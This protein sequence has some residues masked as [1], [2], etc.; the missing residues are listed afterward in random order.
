MNDD[1]NAIAHFLACAADAY[2]AAS[3]F[4][5]DPARCA[6]LLNYARWCDARAAVRAAW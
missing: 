3:Q 1:P 6:R 2:R 4:R 5:D